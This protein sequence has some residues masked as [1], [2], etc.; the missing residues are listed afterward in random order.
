MRPVLGV[1]DALKQQRPQLAMNGLLDFSVG[2]RY[3][4]DGLAKLGTQK[5]L[6]ELRLNKCPLTSLE[7]LPAQPNLKVIIA[8]N[9]KLAILAG[10]ERHPV[11][12]R[13]SFANTPVSQIENFRLAALIVAPKLSSINGAGVTKAEHGRAAAYPPIARTMVT[14]GWIVQYPPPSAAN[15]QFLAD[16]FANTGAADLGP[17]ASPAKGSSTPTSPL[18]AEPEPEAPVE[19]SWPGK[20]AAVLVRLGFPIRSGPKMNQDIVKAVKQLCDVVIKVESLEGEP[21]N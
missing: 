14:R 3:S 10:L 9:S 5:A 12:S 17:Q 8:D 16:E 20:I 1:S 15:F 18:K 13:I 11:L 19:L 6:V 2:I 4:S 7:T 21:G